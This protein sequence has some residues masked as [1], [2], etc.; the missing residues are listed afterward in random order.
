MKDVA[1]KVAFITGGASG[2]G[3]AMARSFSAAGMKVAITDIEQAA[4]DQ[5]QEEFVRSNAEVING[6]QTFVNRIKA[7]GEGGHFV[8]TA[9]M[10]GLMLIPGGSIYTTSKYAVVG[11]LE[12]MRTSLATWS[13]RQLLRTTRTSSAT[14]L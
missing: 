8:N 3:L 2:M 13:W 9:S 11:M 1:G 5:V 6:V 14:L 7:H 4:L 10:A 12:V